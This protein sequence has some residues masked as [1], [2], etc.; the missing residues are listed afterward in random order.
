MKTVYIF[1]CDEIECAR[2]DNCANHPACFAPKDEV[3][4]PKITLETNPEIALVC[5]TFEK[6][7]T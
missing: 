2:M 3:K 4:I 5:E 6:E 7:E 1:E